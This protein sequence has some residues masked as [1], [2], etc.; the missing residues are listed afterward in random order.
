LKST[1]FPLLSGIARSLPL[2]HRF[3]FLQALSYP[4]RFSKRRLSDPDAGSSNRHARSIDK[5]G[6]I[7]P[8]SNHKAFRQ[9]PLK[10]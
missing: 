7:M 1:V 6:N 5:N 4:G 10:R 8:H 3:V 9:L 2:K